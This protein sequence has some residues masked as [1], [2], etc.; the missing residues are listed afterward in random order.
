M[1]VAW[2]TGLLPL[3]TFRD[4]NTLVVSVDDMSLNGSFI[5]CIARYPSQPVTFYTSAPVVLL[6]Q[7]TYCLVTVFIIMCNRNLGWF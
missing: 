3:F 2:E 4:E 6:I 1:E 5:Y 7:G